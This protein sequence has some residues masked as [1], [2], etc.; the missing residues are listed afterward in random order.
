MREREGEEREQ[1][2][3]GRR[4]G[5]RVEREGLPEEKK[6]DGRGRRE[7]TGSQLTLGHV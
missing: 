7:A 1:G 5:G 6:R 4:E 2:R 3:E